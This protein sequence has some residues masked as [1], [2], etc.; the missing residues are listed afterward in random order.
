MK[1]GSLFSS[2]GTNS[3]KGGI[4]I[5]IS[6]HLVGFLCLWGWSDDSAVQNPKRPPI[7]IHSVVMTQPVQPAPSTPKHT[8]KKTVMKNVAR[9]V[10]LKTPTALSPTQLET[11]FASPQ[12]PLV[13]V[14]SLS[15]PLPANIKMRNRIPE[16]PFRRKG[17]K[18]KLSLHNPAIPEFPNLKFLPRPTEPSKIANARRKIHSGKSLVKISK[19]SVNSFQ[20]QPP[21]KIKDSGF[22]PKSAV[23]VP[24]KPLKDESSSKSFKAKPIPAMATQK[25]LAHAR[26]S[27]QTSRAEL[28]SVERQN[29]IHSKQISPVQPSRWNLPVNNTTRRATPRVS[30]ARKETIPSISPTI[31]PTFPKSLPSDSRGLP[32]APTHEMKQGVL[33]A[34]TGTFQGDTDFTHSLASQGSTSGGLAAL[35]GGFSRKV[36]QKIAK[37]R[38]YPRFARRRGWEGNPVVAFTLNREGGLL[39]LSLKSTSGHKILDQA[40][41]DSVKK[42]A[43]YPRIP[44]PLNMDSYSF[45]LPI[46]FVLDGS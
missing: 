42:G 19:A 4:V 25:F 24:F 27:G 26:T 28:Q 29:S 32:D 10:A 23:P 37:A 16:T 22:R 30:F 8:H 39:D 2:Q 18:P 7:R 12:K 36:R 9:P 21:S 34:K 46:N 1:L 13:T 3:M 45:I 35:R 40:A 14:A 17:F 15:K 41:L 5:S 31:R 44:E 6:I 11:P 43:P 20:T 38:F 33:E